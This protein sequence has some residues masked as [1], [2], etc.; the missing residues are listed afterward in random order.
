MRRPHSFPSFHRTPLRSLLR[1][2]ACCLALG[3][4]ALLAGSC[5]GAPKG[6]HDH[7]AQKL[8]PLTVDPFAGL[9]PLGKDDA[10]P[11]T[12]RTGPKAPPSTTKQVSLKFPVAQKQKI[13]AAA[14]ARKVAK[15]PLK[16][17]RVQPKGKAKNVG[18][19]SVT[20]NQ[21]MVPVAS[22]QK[23]R[24]LGVPVTIAPLPKGR[25][26]WLGTR[27]VAFEPEGR[28]PYGTDYTLT[29][30]AGTKSAIGGSLEQTERISF[31]TPRPKILR[32]LPYRWGSQTRPDT[33]IAL[34]FNQKIEAKQLLSLIKVSPG[35]I[36]GDDLEIVPA[37]R[38]E[39]LR[40]IG[41]QVATW[42][43]ERTVVLQPKKTLRKATGYSVT[44]APGLRGEGPRASKSQLSHYFSTYRKLRV[45]LARCGSYRKCEPSSGFYLRFS[46][47]LVTQKLG[48][49]VTV[50]P[51]PGQLSFRGSGNYVYIKGDFA[52][53]TRYTIS[54]GAAKGGAQ[55]TDIHDQKLA[56]PFKKALTTGDRK[57]Q[58]SFPVRGLASM[59][60]TGKRL[61]PLKVTNVQTSRLRMVRVA[62]EQIFKVIQKARYSYDNNGRS[63]PL[64]GIKGIKVRRTLRTGVKRNGKGDV[65]IS[66]DEALGRG[67]SGPVYI[68]LRCQQLKQYY[69][70][71]NPYRGIVVQV[72][73]L[74]LMARYGNDRI[75]G[76]AT[77]MQTGKPIGGAR[78][79]LRDRKG[80]VI[81]RGKSDAQGMIEAPGRRVLGAKHRAP[82]VLWVEHGRDKSFLI[83]D[84]SGDDGG[85]LTTY[86]GWSRVPQKKLLRMHLFTD[87]SPYRPG[88]TVH[89]KGVLRV[90]DTTPTG[91][92]AAAPAGLKE[93]KVE[94][95]TSR[96]HKIHEGKASVTP[97]GAFALD[98][99]LPPGADLGAYGVRIYP[100]GGPY[101]N[102][103]YGSFRVEE[104][105][106]PEFKVKVETAKGP[107]FIGKTLTA[108]VGADY[109][110]GAPM[111]GARIAWTLSRKQGH[112]T[113]PGNP[114][115]SFAEPIPYR[116][117]WRY[118]RVMRR[119]RGGRRRGYVWRQ[120]GA[121]GEII[122]SDS[123][124]LDA[125]G[126]VGVEAKLEQVKCPASAKPN[127]ACKR[128]GP[129]SYTLEAKVTDKN[130]QAIANRKTVVVHP[131]SLY[132]GLRAKK[133]VVRAGQ[134]VDL[135]AV[136]VDLAGKRQVGTTLELQALQVK[137]KVKPVFED[138]RWTYKY[139]SKDVRL[140]SCKLTTADVP[141]SCSLKLPKRGAYKLRASATDS[142]GRKTRTTIRVYAYGP[143]YVPWRLKNQD[144]IELVP[145]KKRYKVGDVA[146]ILVK[147]PLPRALGLLSV[148]RGGIERIE[149][150]EMKGNAQVIEV[151]IKA[152]HLP[153]VYLAVALGRGRSHDKKLGKAAKDLGRPTFA[154]GSV[155]LP[156]SLAEKTLKVSVKPAREVVGPSQKLKIEVQTQ[157]A[158]GKPAA[159]EVALMLVDEG[160]LSL[161]GYKTPDPG[162]VFWAGRG[163]GA[164]LAD[165]RNALLAK[166]KQL[167]AEKRRRTR[168]RNQARYKSKNGDKADNKRASRLRGATGSSAF[169]SGG[170]GLRGVGRGGGGRTIGLLAKGKRRVSAP[171][172]QPVA[173]K[174]AE[175]PRDDSDRAGADGPAR[176]IRSRS[177]FATTAYYNP[178]VLTDA[179]GK[180]SVTVTMPDNLTTFRIMAVVL[181]RGQA[182]RFGKGEAQVKVRKPLLLRPSLPRFLSVGDRFEAAVMVHNNGDKA[183]EIDVLV[184]GRNA[185][186]TGVSRRRVTIPAHGSKEVRFPMGVAHAGP[187]RIQ[188][189]AVMG[190]EV[191]AVE[192]Q[193][194]VLLPVTTEAFATYG[195]TD[196]SVAQPVVP[197]KNAIAGYGG[198]EISM[199]STALNG[200][201]DSVRY[202]VSYPWEC[203]EQTASRVIPIFALKDILKDFQIG[204]LKDH[205]KR[206]ALARAGVRKLESY[207]RWNGGWGFWQGSRRTWLY[208]STYATM[209]LAEA[210]RHGEQVNAYKLLRARQFLKQRLDRPHYYERYDY[211]SQAA[212]VWVLSGFKQHEKQ[213]MARLFGLHKKLPMFARAW[214]MTALYRAGGKTGRVKELL[215]QLNNAAVQTSSAAHFAEGNT[216]SLRLLMHSNDRT[217][218]IVLSALLE[219]A[220][221]HPLMAKL[222]RGL[223]QSRVRGR[224][225]TTQ[226]NAYALMALSRYYAQVEKVVPDHISQIW[227]GEGY[228]GQG[229]FKGREMKVVQQKIPLAALRKLGDQQLVLA[230]QGKGKLYYRI[231]MRYAPKDLVLQPEEQGF[232]VSRVYEPIKDPKGKVLKDTVKRRGDGSWE[233]KAGSTVRV[234]VV[235]VVPDR[236]YFVAVMDPLPAGL[237][238]INLKFK[239]S[240]SSRLSGQLDN[241]TYDSWSWYSLFAFSHREMRDDRV[242]LF[243]DRL[244][245]GV[246][247]Y[248]YLARATSYGSFVVAPTKAEEMYHPETF[249]RSGT[250]WVHIK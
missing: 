121:N 32:A 130:R 108:K 33:A 102:A 81:W 154:H 135:S 136:L 232:S 180:A 226:A 213:H 24:T 14:A 94:V 35:N 77:Q 16:V 48:R 85:Y 5:G 64:K 188:F 165:L 134:S 168:L 189:A 190:K 42:D 187:S 101:K 250:T 13:A 37:A 47:P 28:L 92:V 222:A 18:A 27:T 149:R 4:G 202:L 240:A 44:I 50:A 45:T 198:L 171:A 113:P 212:A 192:K 177:K 51:D 146:K 75:V 23:L 56:A 119:H 61:V 60:R 96:G 208:V 55:V 53:R 133:T 68:E 159:G 139:E 143:G 152:H 57:P 84:Q 20:F 201:E 46:N 99:K 150:I 73:D 1:T 147:S 19:V 86:S 243:A 174:E 100:Q 22:L 214:L 197:P 140:A 247:E 91:G 67:G 231:G 93:V 54:V 163:L 71:A 43:P 41:Y 184:R 183:G 105:R 220:P 181:D 83:L 106:P 148:Q 39:K 103:L 63:D 225:S 9:D 209:A 156:V 104:Y 219:V 218:A 62:P 172:A 217:D 52:P 125:D 122:A 179:Q 66:T 138:G 31:T 245:A 195:M 142:K 117:R 229:A 7:P 158:A 182:D 114:G 193:V 191:D 185:K 227:Y 109:L 115:F 26:R 120:R 224:W 203:T 162:A 128:V 3:T 17:L 242:V 215:R 248:T 131:A 199:S 21:P 98:V 161:L 167:K 132:I 241:R 221:K 72:T 58:L 59:E 145:D 228:M 173:A 206:A 157:D 110:F 112:Y 6:K 8:P 200:L 65:G 89:V 166:K 10:Q 207:Q 239:T 36:R 118:S 230:K 244:P 129:L 155:R 164:P 2:A 246:Y 216:E 87:R 237:E 186:P 11:F 137:N 141:K 107:H 79:L 34:L 80:K 236:R 204:K 153:G 234:R 40:A 49:F 29:I 78:A 12:F 76:L 160:V 116:W 196:K 175:A 74:A 90:V 126:R 111:R 127:H 97:S 88:Q 235:V 124:V 176:R 211:T 210:K 194:P 233:I 25:W 70:W 38:W 205:K 151:P 82:Y 178:S 69:R 169:G 170:L 95:K 30:P 15:G 249:G 223:L 123:S 238:A 144:K